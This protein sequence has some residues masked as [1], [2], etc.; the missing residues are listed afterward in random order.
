MIGKKIKDPEI[1]TRYRKIAQYG[2]SVRL[3]RARATDLEREQLRGMIAQT[4][5]LLKS[6]VMEL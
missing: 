3:K 6:K 4:Q 2:A 5:V 1:K